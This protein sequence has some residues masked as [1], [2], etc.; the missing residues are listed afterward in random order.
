[1]NVLCLG[2]RIIGT[3]LAQELVTT[4]LKAEFS[5]GERHIIRTDKVKAIENKYSK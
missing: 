1:M 3:E 4:F 2:G 5:Y